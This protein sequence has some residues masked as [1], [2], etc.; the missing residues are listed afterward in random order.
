MSEHI[1]NR[2]YGEAFLLSAVD[3]IEADMIESILRANDIPVMKKYRESGGYMKIVM[4][5]SIYGVDLFVPEQLLDRATEII[6]NSREASQDDTFPYNVIPEETISSETKI[7]E[8]DK[9]EQVMREPVMYE[10]IS[11]EPE[12]G[13]DA[14]LIEQEQRI[15]HK[16][17]F[18]SWIIIL[19]FSPGLIWLIIIFIKYLFSLGE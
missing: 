18:V 5:N 13:E 15:G 14:E 10:S 11:G 6:D 3:S 8:P 12:M 2:K 19:L 17:R 9:S 4:G 16:R 7:C 1:E